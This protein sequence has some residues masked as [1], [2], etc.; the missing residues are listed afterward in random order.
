MFEPQP[1]VRVIPETIYAAKVTPENVEGVAEWC[2]GVVHESSHYQ[3]PFIGVPAIGGY[4]AAVV[5]HYVMTGQN[6]RYPFVVV[7][8]EYFEKTFKIKDEVDV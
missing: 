5:G 6:P 4:R 3:Y 8:A 7:E 1:Y 2:H